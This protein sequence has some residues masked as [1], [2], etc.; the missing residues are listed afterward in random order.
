MSPVRPG[1]PTTADFDM[2]NDLYR[3]SKKIPANG[4]GLGLA[5]IRATKGEMRDGVWKK[6]AGARGIASHS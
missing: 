5:V 4:D 2:E 1:N 3:V 6:M